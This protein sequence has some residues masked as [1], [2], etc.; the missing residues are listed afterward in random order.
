MNFLFFFLS[1]HISFLIEVIFNPPKIFIVLHIF[2]VSFK[3]LISSWPNPSFC[4]SLKCLK[5][6]CTC[7]IF[8]LHLSGMRI[9]RWSL[10]WKGPTRSA[11]ITR[12]ITDV[13][14]S[15]CQREPTVLSEWWWV[16]LQCWNQH[17]GQRLQ[18]SAGDAANKTAVLTASTTGSLSR[19][20]LAAC[21]KFH[22]F[23]AQLMV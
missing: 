19:R 17:S 23:T 6:F 2:V 13:N 16:R 18:Q 3:G 7:I 12:P 5:N 9:C 15:R 4:V 20:L 8:F 1:R 10:K 21:V 22:F 11:A 14:A